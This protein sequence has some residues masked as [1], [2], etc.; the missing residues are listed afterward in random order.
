[1]IQILWLILSL[2][3]NTA[4]GATQNQ[5]VGPQQQALRQYGNTYPLYTPS[6][7]VR[8][9]VVAR[10]DY[11]SSAPLLT[12]VVTTQ[13]DDLVVASIPNGDPPTAFN[14]TENG[15]RAQ[16]GKFLFFDKTQ[17]RIHLDSEPHNETQYMSD[18]SIYTTDAPPD[19]LGPNLCPQARNIYTIK[20]GVPCSDYYV[21]L[22]PIP[23]QHLTGMWENHTQYPSP[24]QRG[25]MNW[26]AENITL[27][28]NT[29]VAPLVS[30][31]MRGAGKK[32]EVM[33]TWAFLAF[34]L[35]FLW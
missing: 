29:T 33:W 7:V 15:F 24:R 11:V 14:V 4:S 2:L 16:N 31:Q 20:F 25:W 1:M 9:M 28:D 3:L 35:F 27:G 32:L 23:P 6:T 34:S 21:K 12:A 26:D 30:I 19:Y 17:G 8:L 10:A 22:Y 18:G 13:G 5:P